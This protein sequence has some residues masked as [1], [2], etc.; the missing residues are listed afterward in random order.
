MFEHGFSREAKQK[1]I[2]IARKNIANG[3]LFEWD[4][5]DGSGR[6]SDFFSGSAGSLGKALFEGYLGIKLSKDS[7]ALE[8]RL[9]RDQARVRIY[10]PATDIFVAYSYGFIPKERKIRFEYNSNFAGWGT[11]KILNPWTTEEISG[12]LV[13]RKDGQEVMFQ[14]K[15]VHRD[16]YV[17]IESDFGKHTLEIGYFRPME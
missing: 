16:E 9:G 11:I 6:G 8:P 7:L 15:K 2:E 14:K 1:L 3:G 4:T 12:P 5:K 17:V 10:I 13:V